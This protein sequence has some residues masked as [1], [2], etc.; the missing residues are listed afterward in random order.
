MDLPGVVGPVPLGRGADGESRET[1]LVFLSSIL[2]I[3]KRSMPLLARLET[4]NTRELGFSPRC[5]GRGSTLGKQLLRGM[6]GFVW[7]H[8][9][10]DLEKFGP[11][12]HRGPEAEYPSEAEIQADREAM[13][14][15]GR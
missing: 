8:V 15:A 6:K 5:D 3:E 9:R 4:S 2:D 7:N 14:L 1:I 13:A 10:S 12:G 11:N